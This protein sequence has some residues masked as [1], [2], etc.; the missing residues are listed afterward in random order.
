M[1]H[2]SATR[3]RL[4]LPPVIGLVLLFGCSSRQ[5]CAPSNTTRVRET[6][7][8]ATEIPPEI[9][10]EPIDPPK[11]P[12]SVLA[13]SG[14]GMYG[15]YTAG[16]LAGWTKTGTRPQFDVVTGVSTGSLIATVAFLGPEYDDAA[17]EFYTAIRSADI[18]T[19][20]LWVLIPGAGSVA[21]S[22]PLRKLIGAVVDDKLIAHVAAQHRRGRRLYV[23]TTSLETR[24]LIVWDMGA[25]ATRGGAESVEH[26]R[27]VLL[28]SCSVPGM[29]PAVPLKFVRNG[30]EI[31]ELH[32]DGG[33]AAQL[34]LPPGTLANKPD[35]SPSETDLYIIVAGKLFADQGPVRPRILPV[36]GA[37]AASIL[38][39]HCRAEISTLYYQARLTGGNFNLTALP[40]SDN[41]QPLGLSFDPKEMAR[42]YEVGYCHGIGG[43]AWITAPPFEHAA[44]DPPRQ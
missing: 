37:A 31:E 24:K 43:P 27:Q 40:D 15:A 44:T 23:G 3:R 17:R 19:N 36:V 5:T 32:I 30:K 20:R 28:A 33:A 22:E 9:V 39:S 38:Y 34:F 42:L 12:K 25:I 4:A 29:L 13:L 10:P 11:T 7:R 35:G 8:K 1:M 6:V 21:S 14:G 16:F 18:Y 41:G 26:F 2:R